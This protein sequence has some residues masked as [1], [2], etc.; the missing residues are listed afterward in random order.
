MEQ[1]VTEDNISQKILQMQN[2]LNTELRQEIK[3]CGLLLSKYLIKPNRTI[4]AEATKAKKELAYE[5]ALNDPDN[6]EMVKG[7][8]ILSKGDVV[9]EDKYRILEELNLLETTEE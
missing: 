2:I 4:N 7:D 8:R 1:D 9:T 5:I 6:I 3:N